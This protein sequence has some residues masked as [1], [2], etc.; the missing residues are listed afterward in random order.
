MISFGTILAWWM[1]A[2]TV[3]PETA[4]TYYYPSDNMTAYALQTTTKSRPYIWFAPESK[5]GLLRPNL[6]EPGYIACWLEDD[7][8]V[9]CMDS[10]GN[11]RTK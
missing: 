7:D 9:R 11:S 2:G 5:E 1:F 10:D 6:P 4:S 3:N 8:Y